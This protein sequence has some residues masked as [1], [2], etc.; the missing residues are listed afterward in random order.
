MFIFFY[1]FN[2][3]IKPVLKNMVISVPVGTLGIWGWGFGILGIS[4]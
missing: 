3:H 2:Y 1:I 4:G